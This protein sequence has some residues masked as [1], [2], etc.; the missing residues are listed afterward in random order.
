MYVY[1]GPIE[2]G[3]TLRSTHFFPLLANNSQSPR[4]LR[5][6]QHSMIRRFHAC[7]DSDGR[8]FEQLL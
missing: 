6:V 7:F 4:D 2:N 8:H 3:L 5:I 1:S